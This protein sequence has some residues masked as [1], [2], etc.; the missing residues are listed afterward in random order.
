VESEHPADEPPA[1]EAP[2]DPGSGSAP[3]VGRD[4]STV[5]PP[6]GG[7]PSDEPLDE[8]VERELARRAARYERWRRKRRRRLAAFWVVFLLIL[9]GGVAAGFALFGGGDDDSTSAA[10]TTA[11]PS[12]LPNIP[13]AKLYKV[14][15]GVNIRSGP[16]TTFRAVGTV[17]TGFE[18]LVIC[19]AEGEN[20]NGPVGPSNKWLYVQ[21]NDVN[22]YV[23]SQYVAVGPAINDLK[24][25]GPCP[26]R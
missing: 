5:F 20:V 22:G 23:T 16:G 4:A 13:P 21:Y 25:I 26:R 10:T 7:E 6:V 14:T 9:V 3:L 8:R 19:Q 18:V 15:D 11:V 2:N 12:D 24:V 17:E 1:P